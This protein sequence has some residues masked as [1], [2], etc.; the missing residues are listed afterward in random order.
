MKIPSEQE[1]ET[2]E[3]TDDLEEE[4]DSNLKKSNKSNACVIST[5]SDDD[6][7]SRSGIESETKLFE[8]KTRSTCAIFDGRCSQCGVQFTVGRTSIIGVFRCKRQ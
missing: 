5:S 8:V 1:D 2:E 4:S 3:S 6:D 7:G